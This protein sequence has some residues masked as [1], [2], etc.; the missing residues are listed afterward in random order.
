[1]LDLITPLCIFSQSANAYRINTM[2]YSIKILENSI[3]RAYV[4]HKGR[5]EWCKRT[6]E[7]HL[8]EFVHLHG[9]K[10]ELEEN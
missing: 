4:I 8:K 5:S 6:A 1:V 10:A 9:W 3:F 7:K 2:K